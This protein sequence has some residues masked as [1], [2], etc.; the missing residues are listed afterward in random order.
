MAA[1]PPVVGGRPSPTGADAVVVGAGATAPPASCTRRT[2]AAAVLNS[3]YFDTGSQSVG[4]SSLAARSAGS[5]PP[6]V[7]QYP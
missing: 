1:A 6:G 4:V 5:C 2:A 7:S 3:G